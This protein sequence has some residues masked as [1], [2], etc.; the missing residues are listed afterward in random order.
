MNAATFFKSATK[1]FHRAA[2][3]SFL[4]VGFGGINGRAVGASMPKGSMFPIGK[5]WDCREFLLAYGGENR[6]TR[7]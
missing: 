1:F 2:S 5:V 7:A 4:R 6:H 3:C